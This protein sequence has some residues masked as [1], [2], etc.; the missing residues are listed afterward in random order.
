MGQNGTIGQIQELEWDRDHNLWTGSPEAALEIRNFVAWSQCVTREQGK[1][2]SCR[3]SAGVHQ[4]SASFEP[5]S[6]YSKTH[7]VDQTCRPSPEDPATASALE[8]ETNKEIL[9]AWTKDKTPMRQSG[10][11]PVAA[12][13]DARVDSGNGYARLR[14]TALLA[15]GQ[16]IGS[17]GSHQPGD[18]HGGAAIAY[19]NL[20]S[21]VGAA[22][23][24]EVI[25]EAL[26]GHESSTT[27]DGWKSRS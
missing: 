12:R 14:E 23:A 6:I 19:E 26:E 20:I 3:A 7:S 11:H 18:P 13:H 10:N 1:S 2:G 17:T 16:S 8:P 27:A 9:D 21:T 24:N 4:R 5:L 15:N 22:L 25:G